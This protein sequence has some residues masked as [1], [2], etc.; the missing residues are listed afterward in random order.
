M[1]NI[2]EIEEKRKQIIE[3]SNTAQTF[4]SNFLQKNNDNLTELTF[5]DPLYGDLDLS[6]LQKF[7]SLRTIVF[8]KGSITSIQN[9][10]IGISKF[11]CS[12]QLLIELKNLPAT[13]LYLDFDNNF[14]KEFD[15]ITVPNLEILHASNNRLNDLK[16]ISPNIQEI[17]CRNNELNVKKLDLTKAKKLHKLM[18]GEQ[19]LTETPEPETEPEPE[20]DPWKI[21]STEILPANYGFEEDLPEQEPE[22]DRPEET[23]IENDTPEE[24]EIVNDKKKNKKNPDYQEALDLYFKAKTKYENNLQKQRK[25]EFEK[26]QN[27]SK[28]VVSTKKL[29]KIVSQKIIPKC[30]KCKQSGGTNFYT[31]ADGYFAVCGNAVSPCSL[32]VKLLRGSFYN[33]LDYFYELKDDLKENQNEIIKFKLKYIFNYI[34]ND[35]SKNLF[36][37]LIDDYNLNNDIFTTALIFHK[38]KYDNEEEKKELHEKTKQYYEINKSIKELLNEY[39]N[40]MDLQLLNQAMYLYKKDLMP[41]VENIRNLKYAIMEMNENELFQRK[42]SFSSFEYFYGKKPSVV[43]FDGI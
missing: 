34:S 16:N 29:W 35:E 43:Y 4:F 14:L 21:I 42:I 32:K 25:Q 1:N 3:Y 26:L 19:N 23:E 7:P 17:Y 24:T 8:L 2:D 15:F 6:V 18:T 37:T 31:N 27:K 12:N 30:L 22:N 36:Q 20:S 40:T 39:Q 13:L 5:T 41:I 28:T 38:S 11:I 9:I 33:H 10:P